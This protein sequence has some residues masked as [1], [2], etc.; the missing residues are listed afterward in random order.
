[1]RKPIGKT[2]EEAFTII[3]LV[4]NPELCFV[5]YFSNFKTGV[6]EIDGVA[7]HS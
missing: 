3:P 7:K 2:W 5:T 6:K 4:D 1:M